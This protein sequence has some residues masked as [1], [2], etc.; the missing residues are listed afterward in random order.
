MEKH[1]IGTDASMASH[2]ANVQARRC[3]LFIRARV[4]VSCV[5]AV[6]LLLLLWRFLWPQVIQVPSVVCSK[7]ALVVESLIRFVQGLLL[8]LLRVL[9]VPGGSEIVRSVSHSFVSSFN[10]YL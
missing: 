4:R 8:L 10:S 7:M 1:G 5:L 2:I 9:L 6:L 3:V